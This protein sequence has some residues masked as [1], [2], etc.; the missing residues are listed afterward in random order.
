MAI[1]LE[2]S[3]AAAS[4]RAVVFACDG[5]YLPYAL[6]AAER[7]ALLHPRRDFDICLCALDEALEVPKTLAGLGLRVCRI[8]TGGAPVSYTHLT[9]PTN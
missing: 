6:F 1:T 7:I 9:L 5:R 8:D 4:D 2:A 3:A